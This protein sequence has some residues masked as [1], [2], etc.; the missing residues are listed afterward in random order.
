M[1]NIVVG[2]HRME[3]VVPEQG[4]E[5]LIDDVPEN[6]EQCGLVLCAAWQHHSITT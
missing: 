3:E 5:L 2:S 4:I 1:K 6:W